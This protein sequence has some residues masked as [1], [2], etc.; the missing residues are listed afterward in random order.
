M[1]LHSPLKILLLLIAF[2]YITDLVGQSATITANGNWSKRAKGYKIPEAGNDFPDTFIS[3][4]NRTLIR[5]RKKPTSILFPWRVDVKATITTVWDSR[6]VL[7]VR[8]TGAG[9]NITSGATI[10]D[11]VTYREITN[12]DQPFFYGEGSIK[13]IPIQYKITGVTVLVPAGVW[14]TKTVTYTVIE[15]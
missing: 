11:G 6:L 8:R 4:A 1:R 12:T 13:R 10:S 14:Y 5:V 7:W 2:F 15:L 3:K 9:N